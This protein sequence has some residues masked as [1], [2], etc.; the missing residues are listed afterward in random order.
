MFSQCSV[1]KRFSSRVLR[2]SFST[3]LAVVFLGIVFLGTAS[4]RR[5]AASDD[6]PVEA[7]NDA[8]CSEAEP[9]TS[10]FSSIDAVVDYFNGVDSDGSTIRQIEYD[11][12]PWRYSVVK[13]G[14]I[15]PPPKDSNGENESA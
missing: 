15:I 2:R 11:A 5:A 13:V 9:T 1:D 14:K 3:A 6:S 8:S 4:E 10:R 12:P 7:F